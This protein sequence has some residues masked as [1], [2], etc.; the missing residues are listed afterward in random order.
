MTPGTNKKNCE[1]TFLIIAVD[2]HHKLYLCLCLKDNP[3]IDIIQ[4]VCK[5]VFSVCI[6]K[7]KTESSFFIHGSKNLINT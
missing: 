2:E 1:I 6:L 4:Y 3:N 5:K 7:A